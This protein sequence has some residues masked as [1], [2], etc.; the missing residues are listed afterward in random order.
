VLE[1][2]LPYKVFDKIARA[3]FVELKVGD[4]E[5]ALQPKNMAA[6][7]DLNNRVRP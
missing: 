4:S 2:S 6:L 3:E 7:R 1:V 5:F